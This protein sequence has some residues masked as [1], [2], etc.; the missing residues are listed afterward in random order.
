MLAFESPPV[1]DRAFLSPLGRHA[2]KVRR[3]QIANMSYPTYKSWR[4]FY[5]L[6]SDAI[7]ILEVGE[8]KTRKTSQATIELCQRRLKSYEQVKRQGNKKKR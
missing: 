3:M 7:V 1:A 2:A 5:F 8:K 4:L 6:D